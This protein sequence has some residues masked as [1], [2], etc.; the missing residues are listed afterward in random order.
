MRS[1]MGITTLKATAVPNFHRVC[2]ATT[3]SKALEVLAHG[4]TSYATAYLFD[5]DAWVVIRNSQIGDK[6]Y[7]LSKD[8]WESVCHIAF[9]DPST[10]GCKLCNWRLKRNKYSIYVF[11]HLTA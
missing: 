4:R 11:K 1:H 6:F 7:L 5:R 3:L 2:S 10:C 8:E 9:T